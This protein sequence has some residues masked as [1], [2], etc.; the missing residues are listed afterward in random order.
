MHNES[1]CFS[2]RCMCRASVNQQQQQQH[3]ACISA[4]FLQSCTASPTT[5]HHIPNMRMCSNTL[6]VIMHDSPHCSGLS[7]HR[8]CRSFFFFSARGR[9]KGPGR[10]PFRLLV[11]PL[12]RFPS[13]R[14]A[15]PRPRPAAPAPA[16]PPLRPP[17]G[18]SRPARRSPMP[19][20]RRV[21][22][23]GGVGVRPAPV[24][25]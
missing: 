7:P 12:P 19:V 23:A 25:M 14:P 4:V 9:Y 17:A 20:G 18:P 11:P 21:L 3:E 8:R 2:C 13:V 22:P 6:H 5:S 15:A 24:R 16:R 1:S 10:S